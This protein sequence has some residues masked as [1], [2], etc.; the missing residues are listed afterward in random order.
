M[1]ALDYLDFDLEVEAGAT[2]DVYKVS[3]LASPRGEASGQMTFPFNA[4]AL[5]NVILKLGR[6][7]SGVRAIG[8]PTQD[9]AQKFGSS[10]YD[11]LFAGEVGTCFRRSLDEA[12]AQRKGLRIRLRL[13]G[14]PQLAEVPWEYLYPAGLRHFLVLSTRTPVVR[15]LELPQRVPPLQVTPPLQV[16]V[17]VSAPTNLATLN[18]DAEVQRIR[19]A[20]ASLERAGQVRVTVIP[21][22][23]ADGTTS[24]ANLMEVRRALR[25]GGFH[26][27]HFIGHGGF[28]DATGEGMLAF[29]DENHLAHMV[30]GTTLATTISGFDSLRLVL[31]NACEGARQSPADPLGGVAQS[32]VKLGNVPAVVAM[33]F[34]I[35]DDAATVFSSEFYAA[36][37]DG[38]PIDAALAEAR[39]AVFSDNND[40]E[41]GTPVL[42]LRASDGRIFDVAGGGQ[43]VPA[44]HT[45]AATAPAGEVAGRVV[46]VVVPVMVP[47]W[48]GGGGAGEGS[49]SVG[50]SS[51]PGSSA[52]PVAPSG[53]GTGGG[54]GGTGGSGGSGGRPPSGPVPPGGTG[55]G[56]SGAGSS[57]LGSPGLPALEPKRSGTGLRWAILAAVAAVVALAVVIWPMV[58][59]AVP[60]VVESPTPTGTLSV[61]PAPTLPTTPTPT[62]TKTTLPP[63]RDVGTLT[64]VRAATPLTIDG[65]TDDWQWQ[66]VARAD[67]RIAGSSTATG[68]IYL[69]W[70]DQ[71]LYLLA[72]VTDPTPLPPDATQPSKVYRGD[73]VILELG[74]DKRRLTPADLAR[75]VDAYYMFGLPVDGTPVIGIL[76]PNAKGT[77]FESPRDSRTLDAAIG[78]TRT[79]YVLEARI[80]WATTQLNGVA[81]GA[82]FAANVQ[83][84]ERKADSLSNLGMM[85]TNPQRT[86]ELRAHPAYWQGLELQA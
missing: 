48:P 24:H 35:T 21:A 74:P 67:Q 36:I 52:P 16:L 39:V 12:D 42:Y 54:G 10:L 75:P 34:E 55:A 49:A 33:Q 82:V 23:A 66:L 81:A 13:E 19:G 50:T 14:A 17:V 68:D 69:M 9:L 22:A 3:V 26:V 43:H 84:S 1:A 73:S 40:V 4:D 44:T 78:V 58:F 63:V 31:L 80:P 8:S 47:P 41:W 57:G 59:P 25:S 56:S 38:Y 45:G 20:L 62:V 83:V 77:S 72:Q 29:E 79:G 70:D 6:T 18:V 85:S 30:S 2:P 32:L 28:M 51:A 61:S 76:G 53:G 60:V 46:P 27:L 7:R 86:A 15:Y 71:A 11:A 64:A 65:S 5:E 37:A